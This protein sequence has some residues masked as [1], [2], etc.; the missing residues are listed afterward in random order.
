MNPFQFSRIH[1][2]GIDYVDEMGKDSYG[3]LICTERTVMPRW[4]VDWR[5]EE[6]SCM[7]VQVNIYEWVDTV[8]WLFT[9]PLVC[10]ALVFGAHTPTRHF[11]P[12]SWES[13]CRALVCILWTVCSFRGFLYSYKCS[14]SVSWLL[15]HSS[16]GFSSLVSSLL[17][18]LYRDSS[19]MC[20][21]VS[22]QE[23]CCGSR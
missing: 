19:W 7:L 4:L 23:S 5:L 3:F 13:A 15:S 10:S 18:A 1:I 8:N 6:T 16:H 9:A 21:S 22:F 17:A 12:M 20:S 2:N 14:L 11:Q